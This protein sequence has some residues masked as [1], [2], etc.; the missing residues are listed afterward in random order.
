MTDSFRALVARKTDDEVNSGFETLG[1]DD[2]DEGDVTVAVEYSTLNYKDGLAITG[3]AP[4]VQ[5]HPLILGID[6][7]G[8][9][10][11]SS[12]AQFAAG[13]RV[14]LNGYGASEYM[15]GGYAERARV[16]GDLLVKLP[17]SISTRQAMAIGT[18]GYTAMLSVMALQD[19]GPAPGDGEVL[20]TGAAGG[21]GTVAISLLAGLGYRV[22]ASTGRAD[23]APFLQELGAAA[24]IDRAELS[25]RGK[26]LQKER[27]A[28]VVDCVGSHTL[29]NCLA[30]TR[31]DGIVTACGLAQGADLPATVMP[32]ILRNVQLRGVDSV[33]APMARR[34]K[35]WKRLATELDMKRLE[36]LSFNLP[37]DE[38][39]RAAAD[40]LAGRIRGRAVVELAA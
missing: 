5:R 39:P 6:Y 23:E 38:L 33:Q 35:A 37:F 15:H 8:T 24:V 2:L 32:F 25:E 17:D 34:K 16:S 9:V 1:I 18:A 10:L 28:G 22:I 14:V 26:P 13:D 20:V 7:A 30:Q 11:E 36:T 31:Y 29:A 4:I 27:W 21:V 19:G 3:K 40:I 12:N